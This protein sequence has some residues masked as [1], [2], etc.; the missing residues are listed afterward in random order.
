M[1]SPWAI[2]HNLSWQNRKWGDVDFVLVGPGGMWVFEV[3]AYRRM[4]RVLDDHW[5]YKSR[6]GWG[7]QKLSGEQNGTTDGILM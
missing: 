1:R 3:K 7:K 6:W 5:Q 4:V 2:F